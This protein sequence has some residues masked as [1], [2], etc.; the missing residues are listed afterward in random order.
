VN[1]INFAFGCPK[2]HIRDFKPQISAKE[3][4]TMIQSI[5]AGNTALYNPTQS[6]LA[7]SKVSTT[8]EQTAAAA[9]EED[10]NTTTSSQ[11]DTLTLSASGVSAAKTFT[12]QSANRPSV[13][14]TGEDSYTDATASALSSAAAGVGITSA[15]AAKAEASADEAAVS[16]STSSSSSSS[17]SN[18]SEYTES[19]LKEMLENGEIT[20]AEYDAE[21]QSRSQSES[22]SD[23]EEET[24]T[25]VAES[26]GVEA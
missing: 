1:G 10:E 26:G 13:N 2:Y 22:S 11:G 25:T 20:K 5:Q 9:Q 24:A 21:I 6:L 23:D 15:S 14:G 19:E 12:A 4:K 18:L 7:S 3:K 17:D 16:G 8:Q